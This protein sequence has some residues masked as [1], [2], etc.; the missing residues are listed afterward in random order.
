MLAGWLVGCLFEI[1]VL[2]IM[3]HVDIYFDNRQVKLVN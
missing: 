3:V 1:I 2:L